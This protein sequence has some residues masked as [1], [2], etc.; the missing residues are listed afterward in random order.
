MGKALLII[1]LGLSTLFGT[2]TLNIS[3]HS[4]ESVQTYSSHYENNAA[5]NAAT[6]GVYMAL[7][8]L[9]RDNTW[10][11]GYQGLKLGSVDL[12]VDL[13]DHND[14]PHL[15]SM[16]LRVVSTGTYANLNKTTEV[17]LGI[18]PDLADLAI[19]C[20]DTIINVNVYDESRNPDPSLAIQNA[21]EMLPYDKNAVVALAVAQNHVINGDFAAPDGWPT[22][23]PTKDFYWVSPTIPNV[24]HVKGNFTVNGGRTVYGIFVVEGNAILDGN[25]R[26]EGVLYLPNPGGIVIHGGGDPK[27]SSVTGGI[28]ANGYVSGSGNH[29]SVQYDSDYMAIFGQ[30]QL[31]KNMFIISWKETPSL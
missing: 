14:D 28:F 16:E 19:F 8:R 3:R 2:I 20:T 9:Y 18:P 26:L 7:S 1:V 5:R 4:L 15:S 21:P 27:E 10:R 12:N 6:S 11:T 29:I 31:A 17:R 22:N 13:Q 30:F 25:S 24:T 23:D